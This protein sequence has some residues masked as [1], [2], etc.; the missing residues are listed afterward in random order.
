MSDGDA[1]VEVYVDVEH[2]SPVFAENV[3]RA[4]IAYRLLALA[5]EDPSYRGVELIDC[6]LKREL[7]GNVVL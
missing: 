7:S 4:S 5:G 3:A 2:F 6:A 1:E